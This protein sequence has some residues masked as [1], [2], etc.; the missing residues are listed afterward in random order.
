MEFVIIGKTKKDK[1]DIKRA[2]EKM[3]GKLSTK[4]YEKTA[5]I[6]STE[7][8]VERLGSRMSDAKSFGI[9]VVP[10]EFLE[11]VKNGGAISFIVSMSICDWGTDVSDL[12]LRISW[13][14]SMFIV[15][16]HI[17]FLYF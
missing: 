16:D 1:D 4:I 12:L 9:Q 11:N 15:R 7:A 13:T 6:I 17:S 8:E 5:A 10:E 3:G 2:I 14:T